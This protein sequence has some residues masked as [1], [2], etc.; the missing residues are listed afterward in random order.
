[1]VTMPNTNITTIPTRPIPASTVTIRWKRRVGWN[2]TTPIRISN[3]M[4]SG[5]SRVDNGTLP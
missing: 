2:V 5:L 1:M 4:R 3:T